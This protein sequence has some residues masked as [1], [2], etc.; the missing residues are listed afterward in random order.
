MTRSAGQWKTLWYKA[1]VSTSECHKIAHRDGREVL[2][3]IGSYGAQGL[4]GTSLFVEDLTS[5]TRVLM[6]TD[7]SEFFTAEDDTLACGFKGDQDNPPGPIT[8]AVVKSVEFL[9]AS[10]NGSAAL[11]VTAEF[12]KRT[13]TAAESKDCYTHQS[14][15]IPPTKTYRIDFLFDG[16]TFL[17]TRQSVA[18]FQVFAR[19][20]L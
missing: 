20:V 16:H 1:G 8:R 14:K 10:V 9:P 5:P 7:G 2:V 12:G 17:P 4:I 3:C 15:Y 19:A 18:A 13:L 6:A 11:R